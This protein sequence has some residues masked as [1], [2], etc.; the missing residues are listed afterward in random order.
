MLVIGIAADS[1]YK[2]NGDSWL[3][4]DSMSP[5][6]RARKTEQEAVSRLRFCELALAELSAVLQGQNISEDVPSSLW[7]PKHISYTS[8]RGIRVEIIK[9][10]YSGNCKT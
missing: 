10:S 2:N 6:S 7:S 5:I 9:S 4:Q 8:L 1:R 3:E